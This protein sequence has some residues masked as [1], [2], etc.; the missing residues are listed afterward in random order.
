M[1]TANPKRNPMKQTAPNKP[2]ENHSRALAKRAQK[3]RR[4]GGTCSASR[5]LNIM[6]D[7]L[8]KDGH[9]FMLAEE[10]VHCAESIYAVITALWQARQDLLAHNKPGLK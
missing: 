1:S 5:H 2:L 8:T 7:A 3:V 4:G 9:Y 10:P 6:A